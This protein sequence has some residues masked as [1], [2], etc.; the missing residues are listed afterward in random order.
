MTA[1]QELVLQQ[2]WV[3]RVGQWAASRALPVPLKA[4]GAVTPGKSSFKGLE[5]VL[6]H[7]TTCCHSSHHEASS[8]DCS[9]LHKAFTTRLQGTDGWAPDS[10]LRRGGLSSPGSPAW[11]GN[12]LQC[13]RL[14]C[15]QTRRALR[16]AGSQFA[17]LE[18][19]TIMKTPSEG[20]IKAGKLYIK[21]LVQPP[22]QSTGQVSASHLVGCGGW[23]G[24]APPW[25]S[26]GPYP[27]QLGA[28]WDSISRRHPGTV[29]GNDDGTPSMFTVQVC[30]GTP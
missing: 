14:P 1:T 18:S 16:V 20:L 15:C 26:S 4:R 24:N 22:R 29:L 3:L 30:E 6:A 2:R 9:W 10:V 25:T 28:L 8:F 13:W 11:L 19:R 12:W 21:C 17:H 27:Q 7:N 5:S 23:L